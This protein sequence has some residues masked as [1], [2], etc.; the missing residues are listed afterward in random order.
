MCINLYVVENIYIVYI[1]VSPSPGY[2]LHKITTQRF[3]YIF[4]ESPGGRLFGRR[5][6]QAAASLAAATATSSGCSL[7]FRAQGTGELAWG[8]KLRRSLLT[9]RSLERVKREINRPFY[10][11]ALFAAVAARGGRKRRTG[12]KSRG[13]GLSAGGRPRADAQRSRF[14][15]Q[16]RPN[17]TT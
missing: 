14:R 5:L 9:F 17:P 6:L 4:V 7:R 16:S 1:M 13:P 3:Y 2:D 11:L 15:L 8:W 10:K 12:G